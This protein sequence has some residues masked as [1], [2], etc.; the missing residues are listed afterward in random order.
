MNMYGSGAFLEPVEGIAFMGVGGSKFDPIV[1]NLLRRVKA[2][3][4]EK[5]A[6]AMHNN[7]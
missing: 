4:R 6:V 7:F 5:E 1:N 2:G 3:G